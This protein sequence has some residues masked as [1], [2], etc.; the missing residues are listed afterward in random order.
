MVGWV[1]G[2][3][4]EICTEEQGGLYTGQ[5]E[6]EGKGK[7]CSRNHGCIC[8]RILFLKS[9]FSFH[10]NWKDVAPMWLLEALITDVVQ[11]LN[12]SKRKEDWDW[13]LV[14]S[15]A[16]AASVGHS[17]RSCGILASEFA[18]LKILVQTE[19]SVGKG[20]EES[21]ERQWQW[22]CQEEREICLLPTSRLING[23]II[24]TWSEEC[25]SP[26]HS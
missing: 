11:F 15:L 24:Y 17:W 5:R 10:E 13:Q 16:S 4:G 18:A 3:T 21:L 8:N 19:F 26:N 6:E 1:T 20:W 25:L 9:C 22:V 7:I 14:L 2:A 12:S 23:N